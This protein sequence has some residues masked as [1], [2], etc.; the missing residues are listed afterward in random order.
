MSGVKNWIVRF[1]KPNTLVLTGQI[2]ETW[3][4]NSDFEGNLGNFEEV[5]LI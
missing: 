5:I 4:K 3:R 2:T 1:V